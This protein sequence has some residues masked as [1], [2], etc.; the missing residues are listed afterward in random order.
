MNCKQAFCV[1]NAHKGFNEKG[2]L[3]SAVGQRALT[4]SHISFDRTDELSKK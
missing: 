4:E 3:I 2:L 1:S